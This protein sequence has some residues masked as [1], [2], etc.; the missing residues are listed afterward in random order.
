[1]R[2][3]VETSGRTDM[4]VHQVGK[5]L[6]MGLAGLLA[7]LTLG[8]PAVAS[9]AET[10]KRFEITPFAG[11]MAGGEFE[12]PTN[13]SERDLDQGNNF[14]LIVNIAEES[15]RHYEFLFANMDSEV[16]GTV[17]FDLEIQYL[18]IGGIVSN[19]D[20]RRVIPY[21]GMTVGAARFSPDAADLDDETKIAFS[22]GGGM[23]IPI[24]EHLGVRFDARAFLTLLD[25]DGNLFCVSQGGTGTCAIAA[26][27]DTFLQYSASLGVT[28]AF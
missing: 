25:S 12:D 15:W 7:T 1:M 23:R 8:A 2:T 18:Q 16:E 20:A 13:G 17:P 14:G 4:K 24:T 5:P 22:A 11:Y 21:F 10:Y 26:K 28:F 6:R 27:S 3:G 9:E 19:L